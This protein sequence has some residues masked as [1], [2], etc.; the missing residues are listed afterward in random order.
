MQEVDNGCKQKKMQVGIEIKRVEK[1]KLAQVSIPNDNIKVC[2]KYDNTPLSS[3]IQS[4]HNNDEF[5]NK[6]KVI[7]PRGK[8]L[9][10]PK[11]SERCYLGVQEYQ[12]YD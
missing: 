2:D 5:S 6:K 7:D 9:L 12:A 10:D 8:Y 1:K 3:H 11:E 4:N